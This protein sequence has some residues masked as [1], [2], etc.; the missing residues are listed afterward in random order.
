MITAADSRFVARAP[1]TPIRSRRAVLAA[2]IGG[3][4]ALVAQALG[5]APRA[6]ATHGDVHL[7]GTEAVNTTA[8]TTQIK[9]T[10]AAAIAVECKA[11]AGGIGLR[12]QVVGSGQG[13]YG[14]APAITAS[15]TQGVYG[16]SYSSSG[17]GVE[18]KASAS[19]GTTYGVLGMANSVN[20]YGVYGQGG[21]GVKGWSNEAG[22]P[23][24]VGHSYAGVTGVL[25]HSGSSS[26]PTPPDK[27][28]VYGRATQDSGSRGVHGYSTSGRGV[29]GQA[30]G[31]TGVY[32]YASTGRGGYF[33]AGAT[34]TALEVNGRLKVS[35]AAGLETLTAGNSSLV[36]TPGVDIVSSSKILVTIEGNPGAGVTLHRV[37]KSTSADTFTVYLTG[38]ASSDVKVGYLVI[39]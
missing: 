15:I 38:A 26:L 17:R 24:L 14:L 18:G 30:T 11:A 39:G 7:G 19:S 37:A 23:A 5:H 29:Y 21:I 3:G 34:G 31:G 22:K 32:G 13:V 10:T 35:G 27:T 25:G 16:N 33:T 2:V 1:V 6:A 12:G 4:A 20:G 36:V 28:G 9:C 8:S